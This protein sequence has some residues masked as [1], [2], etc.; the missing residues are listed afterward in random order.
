MLYFGSVIAWLV[1]SEGYVKK[2]LPIESDDSK[3]LHKTAIVCL[4]IENNALI[5]TTCAVIG[6][7]VTIDELLHPDAWSGLGN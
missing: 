1:V 2:Y 3:K 7:I 6:Y 5:A 4:I